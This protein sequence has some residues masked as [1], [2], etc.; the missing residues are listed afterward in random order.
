MFLESPSNISI[1]QENQDGQIA[2]LEGSNISLECSVNDGK[3]SVTLYWITEGTIVCHVNN[4]REIKYTLTASRQ[5]HKRYFTCIANNTFY[6]IKRKT[7]IHI[8]CKALSIK[9][10]S[11]KVKENWSMRL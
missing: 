8:Y 10:I 7:Q 6:Q 3:P 11:I 9:P 4:T 1:Y 5:Y 2:V